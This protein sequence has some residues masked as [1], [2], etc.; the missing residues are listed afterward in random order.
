MHNPYG[1]LVVV[2]ILVLGGMFL[3]DS[4][5][6]DP[7]S[8]WGLAIMLWAVAIIG[9]IMSVWRIPGWH[10]ARAAVRRHIAEH[11]GEMP[12]DLK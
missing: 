6:S 5:S 10:R 12:D 3:L 8:A 1:G 2:L 7:G 4:L 9:L 11:G